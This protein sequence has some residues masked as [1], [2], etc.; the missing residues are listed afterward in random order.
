MV[1]AVHII[2]AY[3]VFLPSGPYP[4]AVGSLASRVL[5]H[6]LCDA[7]QEGAQPTC[8][9]EAIAAASSWGLTAGNMV[10]VGA[11]CVAIATMMS[12]ICCVFIIYAVLFQSAFISTSRWVWKTWYPQHD[13]HILNEEASAKK[14]RGLSK[15]TVGEGMNSQCRYLS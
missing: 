10:P 5:S 13:L 2:F 15:D 6:V 8:F 9:A 12:H 1:L 4:V 14:S 3:A 11:L 7:K